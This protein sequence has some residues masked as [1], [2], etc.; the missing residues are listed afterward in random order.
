MFLS[1]RP[2]FL[3]ILL[4]SLAVTAGAQTAATPEVGA[5][6]P[7]L[8]LMALAG[9]PL[10]LASLL[11]KGDVAL[12]FLRG[13]PGYQCPYCQKQVHGFVEDDA[14]FTARNVQILLVYPGETSTTQM[15]K[16]PVRCA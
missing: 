1:H 6:A 11:A 10:S 5:K 9:K 7:N 8:T 16:D 14:Q 3:S 4:A 15:S 12:V 13:Y 2:I